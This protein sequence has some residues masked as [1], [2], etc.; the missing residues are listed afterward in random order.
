MS[1][2]FFRERCEW[3]AAS[4]AKGRRGDLSSRPFSLEWVLA[5]HTRTTPLICAD[6]TVNQAGRKA[7]PLL[8]FVLL[9]EHLSRFGKNEMWVRS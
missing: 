8:M 4:F 9:S 1:R 6:H 5:E 7:T 2:D 3:L